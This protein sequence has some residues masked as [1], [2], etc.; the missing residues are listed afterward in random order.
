MKLV[1]KVNLADSKE[2]LKEYHL[3]MGGQFFACFGTTNHLEL[4]RLF[5][6]YFPN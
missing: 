2:N 3:S 6:F 5:Y 1:V 4:Y